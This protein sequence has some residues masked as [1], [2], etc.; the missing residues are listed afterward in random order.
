MYMVKGNDNVAYTRNQLQLFNDNE[1]KPIKPLI[2]NDDNRFEVEKI[3]DRK[4]EKKTVKYLV[5]WKGYSNKHNT[6]EKETELLKD[7]PNLIIRYN[8][9]NSTT[10]TKQSN[11]KK[12]KSV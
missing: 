8:A 7:I 10:N 1:S 5:K 9:K 6:W 2:E 11:T 4:V 12:N 3:I